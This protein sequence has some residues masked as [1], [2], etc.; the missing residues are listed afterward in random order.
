MRD[1]AASRVDNFLDLLALSRTT[2]DYWT[3]VRGLILFI[4][5]YYFV[6]IYKQL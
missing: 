3:H 1:A 4:F 2:E 5:Y 6:L